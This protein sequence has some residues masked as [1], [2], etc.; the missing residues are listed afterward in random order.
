MTADVGAGAAV[1][2][3][4]DVTAS[5]TASVELALD[6]LRLVWVAVST[7]LF[8]VIWFAI[9]AVTQ[10]L[11]GQRQIAAWALG[12]VLGAVFYGWLVGFVVQQGRRRLPAGSGGI[13]P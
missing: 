12:L 3:H 8:S 2:D 9:V 13:R 7:A 10:R 1:T 11:F 6:A 5:R 4:G